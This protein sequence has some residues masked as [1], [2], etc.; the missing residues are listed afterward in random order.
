MPRIL[1]TVCIAYED[2]RD[3]E[4]FLYDNLKY[5]NHGWSRRAGDYGQIYLL[6]LEESDIVFITLRY[7]GSTIKIFD[8]M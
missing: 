1:Y 4:K 3:F 2:F 8:K 5:P 7:K 6:E